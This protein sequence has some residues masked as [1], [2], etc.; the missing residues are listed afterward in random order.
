MQNPNTDSEGRQMLGSDTFLTTVIRTT[1]TRGR[2]NDDRDPVRLVEQLFTPEG[3]KVSENDPFDINQHELEKLVAFCHE[4]GIQKVSTWPVDCVIER[5]KELEHLRQLGDIE[6]QAAGEQIDRLQKII[7]ELTE[8][9]NPEDTEIP[10]PPKE[11]P[12]DVHKD[13]IDNLPP[14]EGPPPIPDATVVPI[15]VDD[16]APGLEP[17]ADAGTAAICIAGSNPNQLLEKVAEE[18]NKVLEREKIVIT[19]VPP[20]ADRISDPDGIFGRFELNFYP[21][22]E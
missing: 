7:K 15:H 14:I 19:W 9:Q 6:L 13:E 22:P 5:I 10:K 4:A 20:K 3:E 11:S 1:K 17:L 12:L 21:D 18:L 2:G 8:Q 16:D